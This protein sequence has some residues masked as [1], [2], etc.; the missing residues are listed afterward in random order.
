M[1]WHYQFETVTFCQSRGVS[2]A[3]QCARSL[4]AFLEFRYIETF[5]RTAK[6]LSILEVCYFLETILTPAL[7]AFT[8]YYLSLLIQKKRF[9][10]IFLT[11]ITKRNRLHHNVIQ[12][13]KTLPLQQ[14]CS[15]LTKPLPPSSSLS[16]QLNK[17]A[18]H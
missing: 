18:T 2:W 11:N 17:M 7:L 4:T 8:L 13:P 5:S 15:K 16:N 14:P 3:T 12:K 10:I 1:A 6:R 9:P